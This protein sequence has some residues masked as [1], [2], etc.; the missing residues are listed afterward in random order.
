MKQ[1]FLLLIFLCCLQVFSEAMAQGG[2]FTVT[3]TVKNNS[4]ALLQ[5]VTVAE[6]GRNNTVTTN[7]DGVFNITVARRNA[8]LVV[9]SV[10]FE[11]QE[12]RATEG[13]LNLALAA[14]VTGLDEVTVV[15]YSAKRRE[16]I[17]SAVATVSGEKLRDVTSNNLAQLLQG[18]APGVV[19][20]SN[21][22]DPSAGSEVVVRGP[23][24][25]NASTS[26]LYVVDGNIGGTFNPSDVETVTVLK[27]A[28]ATGLYG[29]RAANGVIIVTTKM[30]KAGKT[31]MEF[32]TTTGFS[33]ATKGNF[34][35]LN[36]QE[37]YDYQKTYFNQNPVVLGTNTD[38]WDLNFRR[39]KV[40][41]YTLSASGGSERTT[42]YVAG[43]YFKEEGT[44]IDNDRTT[45]NLR[46]N[47][48]Q[49]LT[50]KLKL[51]VL[52]NSRYIK[53]NFPTSINNPPFT[54][55][56]N[57]APGG[58]SS[59]GSGPLI[60]AYLNL[61][62]DSAFNADGTGRDQRSGTWYGRDR[63]NYMHARQY[64][65]A[66]ARSYNT[67]GDVNLDYNITNHLTFSTFNRATINNGGNTVYYDRRTKPG[68]A[69]AGALY[70]TTNYSTTLVSSNRLRYSN[71]FGQHSL[72]V[73]GVAEAEK[74]Y[75]DYS[76]VSVKGLPAGRSAIST[77]TEVL[78]SPNGG[79]DS[80]LFSKYL[81][82]ADY[83]FAGK[84]FAVASIVNEFSSRFG[85]NNPSANFY[86]LG[87]SW[88]VSKESFMRNVEP[89]SFLKL[90]ASYG[91]TGNAEGIG[92]YASLGLYSITSAASYAGLP[93][94][95]LS[96]KANPDL[97]WEEAKGAN[98][99][100][101]M[102]ILKR[103]DL[104]IDLYRRVTSSLLFFRG[105]P[106][107]TGYTGVF[108]NVGAIRNKGIEFNLTTRNV[109]TKNFRWE[110]NLNMGFNRN[111]V[112]EVNQGRSEVN[113][114]LTQ[115]VG[116][117]HNMDEWYMPIWA[118]VDPGNGN[119]V[120]ERLIT[121]ADGKSYV[122]YTNVY[123]QATFQYTGRTSAPKFTGGFS[124]TVTYG[125]FSLNAFLNF[126]Y[127]YAVYNSPRF[128][129][130]SDGL[131][132][133]FNQMKLA[134]GWSRWTKPG[135][136][137]THPKPVFGRSDA[138]NAVSSR[139]LEDASY[140]RLRN[141]TLGYNV[142]SRFANKV[143]ISSARIFVSGDNL[144]T[145]TNYSGTDPEA[146]FA[147]GDPGFKYPVSRRLLVGLNISF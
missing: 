102:T 3:G 32:N 16:Q 101:D 99:G 42:F 131:Y 68:A 91:T 144:I 97:T 142:S 12:L 141:V 133:S 23:G 73:L 61:P 98:I 118:G 112:L 77:G 140:M 21:S 105:L 56:A 139:F 65:F 31:R 50:D 57:S 45:Y 28:A 14:V 55:N 120:W 72:S 34:H 94:A 119:P 85:T 13:N 26:P 52:I 95:S 83:G 84:Y 136:L 64:N 92:Y 4:G 5:D 39:A 49:K 41:N 107:T 2:T 71:N 137:V 88:I 121:D 109:T 89:I 62:Y 8:T 60:D 123:N 124:N 132:E 86:Q 129:F 67:S 145:W 96:Q 78:F 54:I 80:Y 111:K 1:K 20:S 51:T 25:I 40:Q 108:E 130:D 135:D 117:G 79:N 22:G 110:T 122:T 127:G 17:S 27:D 15:G 106:A 63:N 58:L 59:N 126:A 36:S 43:N 37:L 76:V 103:I 10:G 128:N 87:A 18:K 11:T 33:E 146:A 116:V 82:Q 104:S 115:P 7:A 138:S 6:K 81:G 75:L 19:V 38:W 143:K 35:L 66:N 147:S 30:G 134:E 69:N 90:R 9:T 48:T 93:G 44:I 53:D 29:S 100:V 114:G 70:N 47:L 46:A 24:T 113:P 74:G 125:R